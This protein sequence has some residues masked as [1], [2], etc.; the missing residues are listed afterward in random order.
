MRFFFFLCWF[1]G[2]GF[3]PSC[4]SSSWQG[5]AFEVNGLS[6][7]IVEELKEVES[8]KDFTERQE[9]IR[10]QF[11]D[12]VDKVILADQAR[13]KT[14]Y[15]RKIA[16]QLYNMPLLQEEIN[17]VKNIDGCKEILETLQRDALHKLD[18]YD[19]KLQRM[20]PFAPFQQKESKLR[21]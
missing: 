10:Q 1:V 18:A 8:K 5:L 3:L 12:L 20:E 13:R 15:E 4:N 17:R 2:I 14:G 7:T 6:K 21:R 11:I 16:I 19:R 9:K